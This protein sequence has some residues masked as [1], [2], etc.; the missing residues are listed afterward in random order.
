MPDFEFKDANSS[1]IHSYGYDETS[2]TLAIRF[3]NGQGVSS[4]YHYSNVP[5][6]LFDRMIAAASLGSFFH[7][8]IRGKDAYPGKKQ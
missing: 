6:E 2:K 7:Q 4:T 1:N 3:K 8:N 5:R